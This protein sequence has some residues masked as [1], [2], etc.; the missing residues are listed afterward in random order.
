[1]QHGTLHRVHRAVYAVGSARL[2]PEG[3]WLA[4]VLAGGDG[5]VL[6]GRAAAGL[7]RIGPEHL[8]PVDV[9]VTRNRRNRPGLVFHRSRLE[10]REVRVHRAIPVTSPLRTIADLPGD[11][12]EAAASRA[13]VLRL[14]DPGE[15]DGPFF[16]SQAERRLHSQLS[17]PATNVHV[18][19]AERDF[20]W[21]DERLIVEVDG[22]HH[23]LP[24]ERARDE[25]RD[26]AAR[27]AGWAVRRIRT[28]R[29]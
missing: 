24:H 6:A 18:A 15:L 2:S 29:R 28:P 16:R 26:A 20:V 17:P 21:P 12:R 9:I 7:W 14:V 19:G 10:D 8:S 3:R 5:A 25:R 23:D 22:P 11:L 1:M 27:A 13:V 4:A